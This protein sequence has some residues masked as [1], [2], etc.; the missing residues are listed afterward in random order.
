MLKDYFGEWTSGRLG[1]G[2]FAI[3]Y[4][5]LLV[6]AFVAALALFSGLVFP[7]D[8]ATGPRNLVNNLPPIA[9]GLMSIFL[10]GMQIAALNIVGKR[11]R[12]AG[13]PAILAIIAFIVVMFGGF[14]LLGDGGSIVTLAYLVILALIPTGQFGAKSAA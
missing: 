12:D 13:L 10:I 6:V 5:T 9:K 11:G 8:Q 14:A 2:R 4:V 7:T 3:L 1:R